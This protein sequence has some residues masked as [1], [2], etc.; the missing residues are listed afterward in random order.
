MAEF[1]AGS[2]EADLDLNQDPFIAGLEA[3]K[4]EADAYAENPITKKLEIDE[5]ALA[6]VEAAIAAWSKDPITKKL[7]I[8]GYEKAMAEIGGLQA[9]ASKDIKVRIAPEVVAPVGGDGGGGQN[10]FWGPLLAGGLLGAWGARGAVGGGLRRLIMGGGGGGILGNIPWLGALGGLPHFGSLGALA[11]F[12]PEHVLMTGAGLAS[13]VAGG[14]LGGGIL[15]AG[16]LTQAGVGMGTDMAGIGQAAGDIR[17]VNS[18]M[19]SL[20]QAIALYGAN[21]TQAAQ[22]QKQLNYDLAAF[23]PIA[24]TAVI[25]AASQIQVFKQ[26][27][28][29]YTGTAEKIGA[30]IINQGVKVAEGFLPIIGNFA[31]QNMKIIQAGLQP[32]FAWLKGPGEVF[33]TEFEQRFTDNLPKAMDIFVNGVEA[34]IKM[35]NYA[36]GQSGGFLNTL[37]R[38]VRYLNS[39][40]GEDK[41][42]HFFNTLFSDWHSLVAFG[43]EVALVIADVFRADQHTGQ[44]II[45]TITRMLTHLHN[46]LSSTKG[47]ASLQNLF[48][49]HKKEILEILQMLPNLVAAFGKIELLASPAV[50]KVVNDMLSFLNEVLSW[51]GV[52]N[53]VAYGI[54]FGVLG[55][56]LGIL[57]PAFSVLKMALTGELWDKIK[58]IGDYIYVYGGIAWE[59]ITTG[60]KSMW[61]QLVNLAK[62]AWTAI[63]DG[64]K[65][66]WGWLV[67]L[68]EVA[69]E[70]IVTGLKSIITTLEEADIASWINP[71]GAVVAGVALLGLAVYEV[72]RNW[73]EIQN[74]LSGGAWGGL[75]QAF[76]ALV[77]PVVG[78]PLLIYL[79]WHSIEGFFKQFWS[80]MKQWAGDAWHILYNIGK[81]IGDIPKDIIAAWNAMLRFFDTLWRDVVRIFTGAANW[82]VNAGAGII[83][84]MWSGMTSAWNSVWKWLSNL[85]H[86]IQS[87]F[88]TAALWLAT[89]GTGIID[90]LWHGMTTAWNTVWA[91]LMSVGRAIV[92]AFSGAIDWLIG[93]GRNIVTGLWTGLQS[94]WGVVGN[95]AAYL[96]GHLV[97]ALSGAGS[98]L[99]SI[100]TSIVQ[101]IANGISG[102]WHLVTD[103]LHSLVSHLP[104]PLQKVIGAFSPSK[105]FAELIGKPIPQGIALGITQAAGDITRAMNA[106]PVVG[107]GAKIAGPQVQTT[108]V[109]AQGP[110]VHIGEAHFHD[111]ADIKTLFNQAHFFIS[112]RKVAG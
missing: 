107:A 31:T 55:Q 86:A 4:K 20:N 8:D 28:D 60:L 85:G 13:T 2:I 49:Q 109:A 35:L 16:M 44:S 79:H 34:L 29:A 6:E 53:L 43:K 58:T 7:F 21:S 1:N 103:A 97:T 83:R 11:G 38:F 18:D 48:T 12:G 39:P 105:V 69:W 76:L 15:G 78:L 14:L 74:F 33:F 108:V 75:V 72:V 59:T 89:S 40:I 61:E 42:H 47:Q 94:A 98:W 46:Y 70:K 54:A 68:A 25:A 67:K 10:A 30:E 93:V 92:G 51:P 41:W 56:K 99:I 77:L 100:G 3:A 27:F 73:K 26:M 111:Q 81:A 71:I 22:A 37:D 110:A 87:A 36:A 65:A 62:V 104:G 66:L 96:W 17:T 19:N 63:A 23:S 9:A 32:L 24:R 52:G 45:D 80:D 84:G 5:K 64:A 82:L 50:V 101:G 91:W 90:G 95:F 88:A 112:G 57:G 106:L 102:A